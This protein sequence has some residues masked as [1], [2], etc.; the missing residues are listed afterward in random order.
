[1]GD[2][3][4][5]RLSPVEN[6]VGLPFLVCASISSAKLPLF[7]SKFSPFNH[8]L[9]HSNTVS[10]L[11]TVLYHS[12]TMPPKRNRRPQTNGL[13]CLFLSLLSLTSSAE[14]SNPSKRDH[15]NFFLN[16]PFKGPSGDFS[17][18]PSYTQGSV[19]NLMWQTTWTS[20][21]LQLCQQYDN[22]GASCYTLFRSQP[23]INTV[24]WTVGVGSSG[25]LLSDSQGNHTKYW[26]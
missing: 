1:M 4:H 10:I 26:N 7:S 17:D 13:P 2:E 19:I 25:Y 11:A 18:N 5:T 14:S 9:S 23:A 15:T 3:Y 24:R 22:E 12:F 6:N 8:D 20:V 21:S 16:P